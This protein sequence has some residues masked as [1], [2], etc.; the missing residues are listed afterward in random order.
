MR[1]KTLKS[2]LGGLFGVALLSTSLGAYADE[3]NNLNIWN[4]SDYLLPE[5]FLTENYPLSVMLER[6]PKIVEYEAGT[7]SQAGVLLAS[8]LLFLI[9]VILFYLLIQKRFTASIVTSGI[10][11]T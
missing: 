8:C 10:T 3:E 5:M 11:G 2:C 6:M 7:E 1:N 9:P 4:W